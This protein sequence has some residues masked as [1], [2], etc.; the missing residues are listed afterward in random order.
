MPADE[1]LRRAAAS[2]NDF[3]VQ[4][5]VGAALVAQNNLDAA[6]A[7]LEKARM[8]FP[9]YGGDN[10]SYALLA[11]IYTKKGDD[12]K[13]ADMLT[14][15]VTLTETN[16]KG[17]LQLATLLEKLADL[18]GAADAVDR[19]MY[20]NPFDIALHKHLADLYRAVGTPQQVV[21]ERMAVVALGPVDKADALT[22]LA[23]A[24]YD[25]GDATKARTT[26]L[27]ALEEAPNYEKAQTLLLT[28]YEARNKGG[29]R[30]P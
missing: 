13:A 1:L 29:E 5:M 6:I 25:A 11:D 18:K 9:E 15:W 20:I 26:I 3:G 14:K 27:R 7:P 16:Y 21:R 17:L 2:P 10:S 23:Q 22:Q 28:I 30:K 24:H 4:L 19:A 8:L 12:R